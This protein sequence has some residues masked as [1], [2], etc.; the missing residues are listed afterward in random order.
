M[1]SLFLEI[2]YAKIVGSSV[3][4]WKIK[5]DSPFHGNGRCPICNDSQK[6]KTLCRFHIREHQ[7]A[8]FVS[9]FNCGYSTNLYSFLK[10]YHPSIYSDFVF[11]K[12]RSEIKESDGPIITAPKVVI[13]DE[14][15]IPAMQPTKRLVSLDLPY[16]SDLAPDDPV[17]LYV[18]RRHIPDYPFQYA[19]KFYEFASQYNSELMG[20]DGKVRRDEPRLVIPF[21]CPKGNV[22]AF[23]GRDLSGKAL[24]KY[25][26]IIVDP[27]VPKIFGIDRLAVK[28]PI[29][30]VEGPIDS[31]FLSNCLASVNA[32]LVAT[33]ERIKSV[34]SKENIT[35]VYDNEPR[36]KDIVKMYGAAIESGYKIVIWPTSPGKKEDINDLILAGQDPEK[37]IASNTYSGLMARLVFDQWKRC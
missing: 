18:E 17:R 32:S 23:Q 7:G 28:S 29:K 3:L 25:I 21:F 16:V 24:Q 15:L 35:L 26:T 6:S 20:E 31:L 19:E 13:D 36:N 14:A 11:E 34:T 8:V 1:S 4:R 9:C 2:K 12:Y 27:K 5:K 37:I 22:F 30:I 33:A 10:V